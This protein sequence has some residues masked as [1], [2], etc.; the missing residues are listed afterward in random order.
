MT[1][2]TTGALNIMS[3]FE[4]PL[5]SPGTKTKTLDSSDDA[6]VLPCTPPIKLKM[7][8]Y[9]NKHSGCVKEVRKLAYFLS[10]SSF[11]AHNNVFY[12]PFLCPLF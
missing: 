8:V 4:I 12:P 5:K 6:N 11:F 7:D 10:P 9:D 1:S 2:I 3:S